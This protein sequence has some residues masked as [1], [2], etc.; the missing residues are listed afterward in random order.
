MAAAAEPLARARPDRR[1][2]P[3]K[4]GAAVAE[5]P[6]TA[7]P[8]VDALPPWRVLLHNDDVNDILHVVRTLLE[9]TPLG[10]P[11]AKEVT[12]EAH[13]RGVALVLT[14]HKERAELYRDQFKSKSLTVTIEP[15][16]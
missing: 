5:R 9:L 1:F 14:T 15:A 7:P 8:R 3:G 10:L 6:K 12:L 2:P 11:R 13:A 4:T 16:T